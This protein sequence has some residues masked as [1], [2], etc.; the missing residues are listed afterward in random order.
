MAA[1][2]KA[3]L[4]KDKKRADGTCPVNIR[5]TANRRT[6]QVA[7]KVYVHERDWNPNK[8]QIRASHD[9]ADAF[10]AKIRTVL[11]EARELALDA[12][13]A[14]AVMLSIKKGSGAVIRD[15]DAYVE[16]LTQRD[17]EWERKKYGVL[18]GKLIDCF[19]DGLTWEQL[20]RSALVKFE[21]RLRDRR[22]NKPNTIRNEMKRFRR[23]FKRAL[24]DR[25]VRA[26]Q[27]PFLAYKLPKSEETNRRKLS[28]SEIARL[29]SVELTAGSAKCL[30]RDAFLLSYYGGGIRLGDLC[31]LTR[32]NLVDGRVVYQMSKT[33]QVVSQKLP[34][35]A[36]SILARYQGEYLLPILGPGDWSDA[37]R[38]KRRINSRNV[39]VNLNLKKVAKLAGVDPDGLSMHVARHSF[40][41]RA[42]TSGGD[43]YA[44]SKALGHSD[45]KTTEI[46]L[47]SFDQDAV[48]ALTDGMW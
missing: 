22:G 15:L 43:L 34:E 26:D 9:L 5:V 39:V 30:A 31:R 16:E 19:G 36:V 35:R 12:V 24:A 1:T 7:T 33:N 41:D 28:A 45:L 42:R 40:A 13:S 14:D 17:K 11:N 48:D 46:Y 44:I 38:V 3:I 27:D 29:E 21:A 20:D 32:G 10:N 47:K 6:K 8:Q 25:T 23:L 18:R 4:R 37:V 2:V